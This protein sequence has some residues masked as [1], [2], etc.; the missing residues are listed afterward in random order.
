M[1]TKVYGPEIPAG[2]MPKY[3]ATIHT[4][5]DGRWPGAVFWLDVTEAN[6]ESISTFPL[7]EE[8]LTG[9]LASISRAKDL[10][11]ITA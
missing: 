9:L 10:A 3:S 5:T 6:S 2:P 1:D 11:A 4:V 8:A 7:S